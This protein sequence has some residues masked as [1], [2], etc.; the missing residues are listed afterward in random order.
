MSQPMPDDNL[1][2]QENDRPVK[3]PIRTKDGQEAMDPTEE[4]SGEK[5]RSVFNLFHH[6]PLLTMS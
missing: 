1:S 2:Q 3:L 5:I 6:L 4:P